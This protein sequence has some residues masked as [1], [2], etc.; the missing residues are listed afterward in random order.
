MSLVYRLA[1]INFARLPMPLTDPRGAKF[2]EFL[3]AV[4][5]LAEASPGFIWRVDEQSAAACGD[6][7][8]PDRTPGTTLINLSVWKSVHALERYATL[9]FEGGVLRT[10][11]SFF[12]RFEGAWVALWWVPEGH[13]PEVADGWARVQHLRRH[14]AT[15]YAFN[16]KRPFPPPVGSAD[17][18]AAKG[19]GVPA[20]PA[21][22]VFVPARAGV[23][24][25]VDW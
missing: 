24:R 14:R 17:Y 8:F 10:R 22:T 11:Q 16:F 25:D 5:T 1:Q 18:T 21:R 6:R 2:R 13:F 7:L 15:P 20:P 19:D 4:N 9:G 23:A 3:R 12:T